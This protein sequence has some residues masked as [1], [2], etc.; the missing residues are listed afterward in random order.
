MSGIVGVIRHD[1][2]ARG[3]GSIDNEGRVDAMAAALSHRGPPTDSWADSSAQLTAL[4]IRPHTSGSAASPAAVVVLS[5]RIHRAAEL[6]RAIGVNAES[7]QNNTDAALVL[8]AY[9]KWGEHCP[10]KLIGAPA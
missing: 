2:V 4:A 1:G 3:A 6:A 7:L 9:E 8:A 10:E 5:G